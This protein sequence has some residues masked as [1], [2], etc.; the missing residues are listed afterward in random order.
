MEYK[1]TLHM[2]RTGFEMR[3]NLPKKEPDILKRWEEDDHY[4]RI[5]EKNEGNETF[6]LH[7]GPP[8][9]NGNLHAGTAMNRIIKDII[10]RS[11]AMAG[12]YTPFFPGWDTHGLPIEN[13][14]QKLGVNRK[15]VT[16]KQFR[17]KCEEYAHQ[18]IAQQMETEK[19]LG[20]V[21]DY[22][23]P[24]ITLNKEFE[25]R[26]IRAFAKM[27]LDGMI[28]QGLKPIYWSPYQE[29]AIA[30]SEIVYFDRKDPTIF[31]TF[32]VKDGKGIL[33][34]NEK[35]VIWTTTPWTLPANVA[36]TLHPN[37]VYALVET[38]KG[39]LILLENLVSSLM[40]KFGL[41]A[42]K[43]LKTFKGRELEGV[44]CKHVLYPEARE[45]VIC[46]AEY[47]TDE[48]GTGC[49][50]TAGGHGL[51]D[52][53]TT[54]RYGLPTVCPVDEKGCMTAEAGEWLEGQFVFDANKTI[55]NRLDENGHLL[56][57]E[58]VTHSYPHDDRL[59]KPVI[60]RA[61][62]QWFASIEKIKPQLLEAIDEVRWINSFGKLRLTNM[63]KDRK[64]WCISRQRLWG[65]PIPIIYNED[66]SPIIEEAV[67]EHIARL[68]DE[69]GSNIWFESS[70][71]DLLPKGYSNPASPNGNFT[72]ETDIMDVWF[73]SGSSW[74][75]LIARG[76]SYPCDLYFEGSDQYR[77]WFNSSLIV[78]VANNG[79]APY[80]SVLSHG[81]VCDSKGEAMHKSV[82][83]VVNPLDII[84]Q[85]GADILRL[86]ASSEDFKADMRIGDSN[87]KQVSDQY[88]KIRN[89]FR[90]MLGNIAS[91]DFDPR[92]RVAYE[93]LEAVDKYMMIALNDMICKVETAY[94]NYDFVLATSTMTN[95]MTNEL[96]SY[97]CDFAKD[98]LY[99]DRLESP[100]RRKIQTVLYSSID[101]LV[102]L[103]SPVLVYTSDEVWSFFGSK[104][105]ESVHYAHF[106]KVEKYDDEDLIRKNFARL[107][108]IRTDI[109]K[110]REEAIN[111]K[112][113]EKPMQAHVLLHVSDEDRRLL[114]EAFSN[115]INQWLIVARVSFTDEELPKYDNVE[116]GIEMAKG[117]V[118]PR[119][120]N[121]VEEENEDGLCDRCAEA[122][123]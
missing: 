78:S 119:C 38:E 102:K 53:Y 33:E 4:H 64:D 17:E 80:K 44:V 118:C 3:G 62:T 31:V 109:F 16:P 81:Y 8:Y 37:L 27:A 92:E 107:H 106:P 69:H 5:L 104:E 68:F 55:T 51:D 88:R 85:Y 76:Y 23:H 111:N 115:K 96:S 25:G 58:W 15:E 56:K 82:G 11:K 6:V 54:Q 1:E 108:E 86:W 14:V 66:G 114:E 65:V 60:F 59:K 77:G 12:Y 100:R 46:L 99:C 49:V 95:F 71:L 36:I 87:L 42:Y 93:E 94:D 63:V 67:F 52:F 105:A 43:T 123:K 120:W 101:A 110:A 97:Y 122:L 9:A 45:S 26:Q 10:V 57:L 70:A 39:K 50:H 13:A 24:Y 121:I 73:D 79:T 72:K 83:N 34:G 2:P 7:D 40:E 116:V 91:D 18:Q 20:Q 32:D 117:H 22:E 112:T 90:F 98:I 48:D 103:W 84:K 28:F 19:R 41:E 75:E 113:I 74:S 61:T 35:F 89:T 30:D 29:T 21:G 47:V